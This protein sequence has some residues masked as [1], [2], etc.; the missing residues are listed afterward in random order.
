MQDWPTTVQSSA[1]LHIG[2]ASCAVT[3][4]PPRQ[5]GPDEPAQLQSTSAAQAVR[6]TALTHSWALGHSAFPRHPGRVPTSA[7]QTESTQRSAALHPAS[8]VHRAWQKPLMQL[9]FPLQVLS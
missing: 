4:T 9:A 6:H 1:S 2:I 7:W 8:A 5:Y 3:Q